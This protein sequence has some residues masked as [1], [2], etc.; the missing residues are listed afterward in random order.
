M[1]R[2]KRRA[3][4]KAFEAPG[5][6]FDGSNGIWFAEPSAIATNSEKNSDTAGAENQ[7]KEANSGI[8]G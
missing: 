7:G 2:S 1:L 3:I 8:S 4:R 5:V 6:T